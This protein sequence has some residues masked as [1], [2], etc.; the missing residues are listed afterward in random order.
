[1]AYLVDT[2][3]LWEFTGN[4]V[5]YFCEQN[6]QFLSTLVESDGYIG[7]LSEFFMEDKV[8]HRMSKAVKSWH[9]VRCYVLTS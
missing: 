9:T 5:Q 3:E 8:S 6:L 4:H 1:M 7:N 2:Y